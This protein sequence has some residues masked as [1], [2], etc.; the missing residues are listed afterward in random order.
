MRENIRRDAS[1]RLDSV[2]E[3]FDELFRQCNCEYSASYSRDGIVYARECDK[4]RGK[5]GIDMVGIP[6]YDFNLFTLLISHCLSI[7]RSSDS[8]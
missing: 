2:S 7:E 1:Q 4:T 3:E 8:S 6:S 5:G